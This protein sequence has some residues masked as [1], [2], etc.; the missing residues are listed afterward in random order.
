MGAAVA[1]ITGGQHDSPLSSVEVY[2]NGQRLLN[3]PD[4]R[5]Y[6][7]IDL[8]DSTIILC[9]GLDNVH[10]C[11]ELKSS[12]QW[13]PHSTTIYERYKHSS[14]S[15]L[16]QLHLLGGNSYQSSTEHI[17]PSSS[18]W[19][20]GWRLLEGNDRACT[21]KV[22]AELAIMTGG[23]HQHSVTLYNVTS[24]EASRL[25]D[26]ISQRYNHGCCYVKEGGFRGV[27]V[28]GGYGTQNT[29]LSELYDINTGEWSSTHWLTTERRNGLRMF[30]IGD[31]ILASGGEY[32]GNTWASVERF[33]LTS[34]SWTRAQ[35]MM[36]GRET[37]AV[38]VIPPSAVGFGPDY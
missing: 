29:R 36:E 14:I 13:V 27:L 6:H 22:D 33:N 5:F 3:L 16:G 15:A 11:L 1:L 26:L 18:T 24:G 10:S 31:Q 23:F 30:V 20:E 2:P 19:S 34:R 8:V 7:T 32:R 37:H 28:A 4:H 17:S 12:H 21:A 25:Q 38:T 9:G 35:D